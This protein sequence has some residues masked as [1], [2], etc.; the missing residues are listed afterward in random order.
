[1]SSCRA[2]NAKEIR[3]I[4]ADARKEAREQDADL[5]DYL[6]ELID[7]HQFVIY[8]HKARAVLLHS[9]NENA[10]FEELGSQEVESM[11]ELYSKA[12]YFAMLADVTEELPDED[13]ETEEE[14]AV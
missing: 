2:T 10:I 13:E 7:G 11:E 8:V 3:S 14:E 1:M 12:A 9:S 4:A 5:H 6:H